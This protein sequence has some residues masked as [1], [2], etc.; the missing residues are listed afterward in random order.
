MPK[1]VPLGFGSLAVL[2][3]IT[4]TA[5]PVSSQ[6][7]RPRPPIGGPTAPTVPTNPKPVPR[8]SA[9]IAGQ[10]SGNL[11][12]NPISAA[13]IKPSTTPKTFTNTTDPQ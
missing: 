12:S 7:N 2:T 10:N 4:L 8:P 1:V 5:L 11:G 3:V 9:G 6:S 13:T